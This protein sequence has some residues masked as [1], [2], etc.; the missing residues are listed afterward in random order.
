MVLRKKVLF[1]IL[2]AAT[3]IFADG[4][5]VAR[6]G[7][8]WPQLNSRAKMSERVAAHFGAEW[9]GLFDS[10]IGIG[11][12]FDMMFTGKREEEIVDSDSSNYVIYEV[13]DDPLRRR[14]FGIGLGMIISPLSSNAPFKPVFRAAFIPTMNITLHDIPD[15]ELI[16]ENVPPKGVYWGYIIPLGADFHIM[17]GKSTSIFGG[18]S[19]RIGRVSKR[20]DMWSDRRVR[21]DL[22]GFE[23]RVGLML[24]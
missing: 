11:G 3:T 4:Y 14:Q 19:Y 24:W 18:A 15:S 2:I 22:N 17:L 23:W 1:A 5:F 7:M 16:D 12:V 20:M 6:G 10:R 21:Q 13:T 9:G 8:T